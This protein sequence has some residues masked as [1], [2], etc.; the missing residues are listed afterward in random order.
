MQ[1]MHRPG[2]QNVVLT[3]KSLT[4]YAPIVGQDVIADIERLARPFKGARVLHIS[5]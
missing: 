3:T 4:D 2:M 5:P 1:E